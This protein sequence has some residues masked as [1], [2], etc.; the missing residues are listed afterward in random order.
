MHR[1]TGR[2]QLSVQQSA[3]CKLLRAQNLQVAE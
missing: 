2:H 1:D 3:S